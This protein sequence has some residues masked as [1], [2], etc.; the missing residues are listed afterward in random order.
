M[1]KL[2]I[3]QLEY[4]QLYRFPK[5]KIDSESRFEMRI[6]IFLFSFFWERFDYH[7]ILSTIDFPLYF[8]IL[9]G[10]W[11]RVILKIPYMLFK[12]FSQFLPKKSRQG[13]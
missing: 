1:V 8:K 13:G 10:Q 11:E 7:R 2:K 12:V 6:S 4:F 3:R 5:C 9:L